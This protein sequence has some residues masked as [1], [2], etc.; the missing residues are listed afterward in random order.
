MLFVYLKQRKKVERM[1]FNVQSFGSLSSR[2]KSERSAV[3]SFGNLYEESMFLSDAMSWTR[4]GRIL[5]KSFL[6]QKLS[7]N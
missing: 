2:Q 3:F 7:R 4:G 1:L 5:I 6:M